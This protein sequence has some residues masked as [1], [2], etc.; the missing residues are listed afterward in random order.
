MKRHQD[1]NFS[2]RK[3]LIGGLLTVSETYTAVIIE[4]LASN[5]MLKE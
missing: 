4:N 2:N 3:Q 1:Q 5:T